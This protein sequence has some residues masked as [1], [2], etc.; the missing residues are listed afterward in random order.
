M[1][2]LGLVFFKVQ[3]CSGGKGSLPPIMALS[4]HPSQYSVLS[5]YILPTQRD[6]NNTLRYSHRPFDYKAPGVRETVVG[7]A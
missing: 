4:S 5:W 2:E 7:L 6:I 3:F 1:E